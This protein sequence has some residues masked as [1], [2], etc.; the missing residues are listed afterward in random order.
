M[1]RI[2][3]FALIAALLVS[4]TG[5]A[6]PIA[7]PA[8]AVEGTASGSVIVYKG[9]PYAAPPI[10]DLRWREPRPIPSW[11]GVRHATT[12]APACMQ[13]GASM[14]GETPPAVSEDCLYLN[15]WAPKHAHRAPVIVWIHG[16]GFTNGNA[17]MPLYWGD[18]LAGRGA[19]LVTFGYRL[20]ALGFLAHPALTTESA[21]RTSGNYG[22][23]DQI[24]ALKWV[25]ANIAALG[26][27]PARI[28]IAGQSAGA[29]SVSLLLASPLAKGLFT[30]AIAQ[31]G[32]L[33]EP[34]QLAPSYQLERAEKDGEAYA[35]SL[36]ATSLADLR[37]MPAAKLL[38]GSAGSV[39]HPVLDRTV[40][41]L[42]PYDAYVGGTQNDV[43]I[44][45]GS[46]DDE[47][48][49]LIPDLAAIRAASFETDI[50]KA[51][52]NLPPALLAAYPYA[53][54][55]EAV[56]ARLGFERDLRFGWDM[57]AWARLQASRSTRPVFYY[58]FDAT[59]PFPEKSAYAGWGPSHYAELWYM[60]DH[61]NQHP[62]QWTSAD[63]LL[64][65][66]M[67]NYWV[68]FARDGN[69]NSTGL[70]DWPAFTVE[71]PATQYLGSTIRTGRPAHLK[72]MSVFDVTYAG[73]RGQAFNAPADD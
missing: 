1:F 69:P 17:S 49:S 34:V 6:Q 38:D 56:T 50:A 71:R 65:A 40:L 54:D 33:F 73:V 70:P 15:I 12:F 26:G 68:N 64:S 8:G 36:G 20:G 63:K 23:L 13:T 5:S 4:S 37:A 57:W 41:P 62:W 39:S 32:G 52:G 48:R 47:A 42:S 19:I 11:K 35:Q 51:W 3:W 45:I 14:P 24:A 66:T 55:A 31:S 29:T 16:G 60:F 18:R 58:H 27:D 61:L 72:T 21:S 46:N 25:K 28:T 10:G 7:S 9:I 59:P 53:S 44:L 2:Q 43:P 22:L 30:G 67:A